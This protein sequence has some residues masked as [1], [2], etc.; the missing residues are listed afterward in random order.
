VVFQKI[1][2]ETRK[3][4][5]NWFIK[6]LSNEIWREF[7][8]G[9]VLVGSEVRS[10]S[11]KILRMNREVYEYIS[12]MERRFKQIT[13][14]VHI[15]NIKDSEFKVTLGGALVI[16][17][18]E[19]AF[20]IKLTEKGEKRFLYGRDLHQ[21]DLVEKEIDSFLLEKIVA[22]CNEKGYVLGLGLYQPKTITP[23]SQYSRIIKQ[24]V[25]RGWFLRSGI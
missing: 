22:I 10:D 11:T 12:N 9:W 13:A 24:I 20:R 1:K 8:K 5:E 23:K 16:G 14:G 6:N 18:L 15:G 7:S 2:S 25:D 21:Q 19:T 3:I 4:I 17:G